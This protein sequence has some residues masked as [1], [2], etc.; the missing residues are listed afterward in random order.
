MAPRSSMALMLCLLLLGC[1]QDGPMIKDRMDSIP[2]D[3]DKATTEDDLYPPQ[4]HVEGWE[5]PVP[6]P[7]PISTAGA[8]DSPFITPD[9]KT[10]YFFFTPD[11]SIPA[12]RQVLDGVTGIYV[13][14]KAGGIWSE[15]ERV[16]LDDGLSMDGCQFVQGDRMWFCSARAENR[17]GIEWYTAQY[18]DGKWTNWENAGDVLNLKYGV[19]ELHIWGDELYHH[20]MAGSGGYDIYVTKR[21]DGEWQ[22]PEAV[23]AVN[24]EETEGWPYVTS[25]GNELW[26]L[27][28]YLGSPAIYRSMRVNGSWAE[29][30]LIISQFAGEPSL[31]DEGNI[32]FVHHHYKDAKMLEADIY[33]AYRKS[34]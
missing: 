4:L 6:V 34:T 30:E 8:E 19:G 29:P 5:D 1:A 25:D 9:G 11:P 18:Q 3:A 28:T 14:R 24:T 21:L 7:Y 12:E 31:D 32:Y 16:V 17:R 26:F 2:A 20:K 33:V 10:L 23:D 13:S 15:P 22:K 27:R